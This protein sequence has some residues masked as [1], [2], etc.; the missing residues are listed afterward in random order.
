[1]KIFALIA[2]SL[3]LIPQILT[4]GCGEPL[5]CTDQACCSCRQ[6][7]NPEND[8]GYLEF[9]ASCLTGG[10]HCVENTGCQLCHKPRFGA[11][12]V[13]DRPIC[14]RFSL[15]EE[16]CNDENC[17]LLHQIPNPSD[18]NGYLEFEES[19]KN[20]GLHCVANS[21]CRLCF[22]PIEEFD[23]NGGLHF[24][25]SG[26]V[27]DRPICRRFMNPVVAALIITIT[28]N[29]SNDQCCIDNQ[30]PNEDNGN[31]FLEFNADCKANGGGLHCIH[32]SGCRL[33]FKP[34]LGGTNVGDRPICTRF[35]NLLPKCENSQCCFDLQNPN[36]NDGN[37]FLEF[38]GDC[39]ANGGGL[40]CV[41]DTG[42][43][44]CFKPIEE[45]INVGDRP[46]CQRFISSVGK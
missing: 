33:C 27:G 34:V 32:D 40:H 43:K 39:K 44:M 12:N 9:V 16:Q 3:I 23:G 35:L 6:N 10:L 28:P 7:P 41:H 20:G 38:D 21:G 1:M 8:N 18:G 31:G 19:C 46:V 4:Q 30:N 25:V 11:V 36:E 15:T 13:G 26:N 5:S 29:C 2:I 45:S 42:C 37:G 17:C 24:V 22:K 14:A